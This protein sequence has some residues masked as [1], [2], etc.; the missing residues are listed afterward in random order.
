MRKIIFTISILLLISC[1]VYAQKET[2][3]WFFGRNAGLNFKD[4]QTVNTQYGA[5]SG[6]PSFARGPINTYEGCFTISDK[7][8]NFLFA[9][10]GMTVYNKNM[11]V[12]ANGT[13]LHGNL[14]S[15]QSGIVI[16]IPNTPGKYYLLAVP[17]FNNS[18]A[19]LT[20]S[21]VDLSLN[22]GLGAVIQKNVKLSLAPLTDSK[23][24]EN[25]AVVGHAN[26]SDFWLASRIATKFYVWHVTQHGFSAPSTYE[27]GPSIRGQG[28]LR[29]SSDGTKLVH[30]DHYNW[31]TNVKNLTYAD[32]NTDTGEIRNIRN[33]ETG[34]RNIYGV[35]FS[36]NGKYLY[37]T[38]ANGAETEL[39]GLFIKPTDNLNAPYTSIMNVKSF[40]VQL[41]AGGRIYGIQSGNTSLWCILNPDEGGSQMVEIKNF[42]PTNA[43]PELGLPPFVTSFFIPG[44]LILDPPSVCRNV[45]KPFSIRINTGSGINSVTKIEWDFGDGSPKIIETDMNKQEYVQ[46]HIYKNAGAYTFTLTPYRSDGSPLSDKIIKKEIIVGN[47]AIPVNHNIINMN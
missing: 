15:T 43:L 2:Y 25:L 1:S 8:G 44:E 21:V 36:P 9:S 22:G 11:D 28:T 45:P 40:N 18:A 47:C 10:D 3:W 27:V 23:V 6:I 42:F 33:Y 32:F 38:T 35:E 31:A 24:A 39:R 13:G 30:V 17:A 20:Y 7:D 29:I 46:S 41:G 5:I 26:G 16:P 34:I 37:I 19:G 12:M 14:S 4:T